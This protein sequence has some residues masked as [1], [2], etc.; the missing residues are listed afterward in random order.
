MKIE[1]IGADSAFV[2]LN[3]SFFFR[4]SLGRG[5]L[6][7]CG[8]TVYPELVKRKLVNDIDIV[9]V[10]HMH[11]DHTGS[12]TLFAAYCRIVKKQKLI[13]GGADVSELFKVQGVLPDDFIP[14]PKDDPINL[15]TFIT[16][17]IKEYGHNTA[18]FI[19]NK[20]LYSGDTNESVLNTEFAE[21]AQ[22][23]IHESTLSTPAAHATLD[24]LNKADPEI[25]AKTWLTHIPT[26]E[27]SELTKLAIE[28]G[29]AGVCENGQTIEL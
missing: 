21:K 18:M 16:S 10:S 29:F 3:S 7:D 1:I 26:H 15:K 27:R 25:K 19:D 12:L 14:L 22:I 6:V 13:I 9:L 17:H 11:A 2:G 23:I 4:D 24:L 20:I 8:F 28:M 5:V